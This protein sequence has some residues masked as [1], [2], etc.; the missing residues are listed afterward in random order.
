[1]EVGGLLRAEAESG[2]AGSM[3]DLQAVNEVAR[4]WPTSGWGE[5]PVIYLYRMHLL[6]TLAAAS[7]VSSVRR[8]GLG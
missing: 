4:A 5:R 7:F 8:G 3:I 1:V 2:L 6:R